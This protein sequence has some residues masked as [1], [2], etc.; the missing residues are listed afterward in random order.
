VLRIVGRAREILLLMADAKLDRQAVE[1]RAVWRAADIVDADAWTHTLAPDERTEIADAAERAASLG[2]TTAT[3][4]AEQF[5]LPRLT[6][7]ITGWVEQLS[8]GRGFVLLRGFPTDG[9]SPAAIELAYVGL[10]LHLG[11]PVSQN[12]HGDLLGHVV[13]EGVARDSPA[14]RLY[15]TNQRQDFHTDGA[16][17]VGLL[18]LHAAKAGG[19]S[20]IASSYAVYNEM[21]ARRPDLVDTLYEPLYWDRN[22]EQG[23]GEP[24]FYP[25]PVFTDIDGTP[26]IFYIGWYI[27][28]AQRHPDAPRL[29][30]AQHD[31]MNMLEAIAN[32]PEFY[33][34]MDFQP[35]DIQLLNNAKILHSREAYQDHDDRARRRHLLRLWLVAHDFSSV[36]DTLRQGIPP[37]R[38]K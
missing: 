28:D 26:R 36:D 21:L 19:E 5:E 2:L 33:V 27:R 31:A 8:H 29:T 35:G 4:S 9:L 25:L 7:Q 18:C 16:D 14:V 1:P 24:A 38:P 20:R 11:T 32:D 3:L 6:D 30:V 15:R 37:R 12:A 13:D 34:E 22:D 23:E 17:L 10:G